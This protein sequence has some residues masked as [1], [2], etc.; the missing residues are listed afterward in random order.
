VSRIGTSRSLHVLH[1]VAS[2]ARGRGEVVWPSGQRGQRI[3]LVLL[4]DVVGVFFRSEGKRREHELGAVDASGVP[5][6]SV[7]PFGSFGQDK[8][9]FQ[10]A[11][12]C[13]STLLFSCNLEQL[14]AARGGAP[15]Q[16]DI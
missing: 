16:S 2:A 9:A 4:D 11:Q 6:R 15:R 13:S 7:E 14:A 12:I 3:R 1:A 5:E 10:A 8:V